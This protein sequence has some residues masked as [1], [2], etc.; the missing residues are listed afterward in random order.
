MNNKIL[1]K[2][3]ILVVTLALLAVSL[4]LPAQPALARGEPLGYPT[5]YRLNI[6]SGPATSYSIIGVAYSYQPLKL[7]GRNQEITWLQVQSPDGNPGWVSA[8]YIY[9]PANLFN[10]PV[11]DGSSPPLGGMALGY[12]NVPNLNVRNGPGYNYPII[13]RLTWNSW[14][15]LVGRN[16]ASS[17][18]QIYLADANRNGWVSAPYISTTYPLNQLPVVFDPQP[19]PQPVAYVKTYQLNFREGPGLTFPIVT[20][21]WHGAQVG[22]LGR[23]TDGSWVMVDLGQGGV[24]WAYTAYLN[25]QYPIDKLPLIMN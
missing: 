3:A 10:L 16:A 12:V 6:R 7:L 8:A 2:K 4:L 19:G 9:S 13:D 11:V 14:V 15:T 17:W 25:S 23:N 1:T 24:A 22:L 5:V 20:R 18:L 21:L